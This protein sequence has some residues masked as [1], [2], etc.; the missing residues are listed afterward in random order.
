LTGLASGVK[1]QRWRDNFLPLPQHFRVYALR[2]TRMPTTDGARRTRDRVLDAAL[3]LFNERG[4]SAVTTN[5]VAARAG[6]SPGNLY[7][8]FSDKDE[9]VRELYARYVAAY[10][11]V[12]AAGNSDAP[13]QGDSLDLTPDEVLARLAD[14]AALSRRFIFLA[15]DLLGLLHADPVLTAEYRA[16]RERRITAFTDLAHSWRARGLIRP[17]DD[18]TV[19]DLVHALWIIAETWLAFGELDRN[20]DPEDG[21]RLLRVVLRPYLGYDDG[22]V[23]IPVA[24]ELAVP[25]R[26]D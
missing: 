21:T 20:A 15:R 2:M 7:Y 4:S 9:I 8:W 13:D 23:A 1:A 25:R 12:W 22:S 5:H 3:E 11:R 16:V 24:E 17:V 19:S 10:E 18:K 6:I 14:G 26:R